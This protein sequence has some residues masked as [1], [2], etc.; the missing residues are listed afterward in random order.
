[1]SLTDNAET[2][3]SEAPAQPAPRVDMSQARGSLVS[4]FLVVALVIGVGAGIWLLQPKQ[5]PEGRPIGQAGNVLAYAHPGSATTED[6]T[7]WRNGRKTYDSKDGAS[8]IQRVE[9]SSNDVDI[10]GS[11]DPDLVLYT[12]TGG[13]HC[14][15]TQILIDG[16]SGRRLGEVALG[17][18]DPTPFIPTTAK[19]LARAVAI[20]VDDVTAFQFGSYAESPM[21]RVLIVFEGGRFG[22]DAKRMKATAPD[23]PPV[24]FLNEPQLSEAASIG[25]QDFGED[26]DSPAP[27][28]STTPVLRGERAQAYQAWMA[29][30]E[31]R[32]RATALLANDVTSYGPMAAFLNERIYKGQATAGVASVLDAYK[33]KPDLARAALVYYFDVLGKSRWLS[34]LDKLNDGTLKRLI[35]QYRVIETAAVK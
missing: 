7:I 34:D 20:N 4:A 10:A 16:R 17:N 19:G 29:G 30:E 24:F 13:A 18:G 27:A 35:G 25:V 23:T 31:A 3:V 5:T 28:A 22:L 26:E 8:R 32:M 14:C 15:F 12:W 6:F 33:D 9:F 2:P 11:P 1:V 21:A